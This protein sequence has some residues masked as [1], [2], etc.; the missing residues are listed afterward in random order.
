MARGDHLC[1]SRGRRY[2]H[3]GIDC[4]DGTVIHYVGPRGTVRYV[5][6]TSIDHFARGSVVIR[7]SYEQR[8]APEETVRRAESQLGS[9]GYSL[10]RN[11]CEHLATWCCTG[12][13]ASSQVRRWALA[14][15]ST[16]GSFLA[17][18]ALGVHVLVVGTLGAGIYA[19]T[20]PLRRR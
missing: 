18:Q 5:G 8:L 13:K 19:L 14:V 3:H 10:V 17:A 4:G 16:L 11:N 12:R 2:T 20:R 9:V 15:Q 6:R 7:R 1:V